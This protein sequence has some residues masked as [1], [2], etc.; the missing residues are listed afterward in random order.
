MEA[1]KQ[2]TDIVKQK[3]IISANNKKFNHAAAFEKYG[4]IDWAQRANYNIGDQVYIYCTRPYKKIMYKTIVTDINMS[5]RDCTDCKDLWTDL[6]AYEEAKPGKYARLKLI[7]QAHNNYLSLENLKRN[8]LKAAP[9]KAVKM[10]PIL[11]EYVD[12]YLHDSIIPDTYPDS[13]IPSICYEG[14]K[15]KVEVNKYERSSIA[16]LKCIEKYGYD[17]AV[18]G[19]NFE[20]VYGD[21][22]KQFIHVHHIVPISTIGD[23]YKIDYENDLV[24]VCPNCHAML[25]RGHISVKELKDIIKKHK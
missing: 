6:K 18:C 3:W 9:E 20:K 24:P 8:G 15:I 5:F 14:A 7:G 2:Q 23:T 17:C 21:I 10:L 22:G 11:A 16:R 1:P 4:Y 19:L 12:T 25:H 13:D